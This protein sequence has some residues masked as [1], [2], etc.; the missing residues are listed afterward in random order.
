MDQTSRGRARF[1]VK[2][3]ATNRAV[4]GDRTPVDTGDVNTKWK[5]SPGPKAAMTK[6]ATASKATANEGAVAR[7]AA[8]ANRAAA[9]A[10]AVSKVATDRVKAAGVNKVATAKAVTIAAVSGKANQAITTKVDPGKVAIVVN[11]D[12]PTS[13]RTTPAKVKIGLTTMNSAVAPAGADRTREAL[14]TAAG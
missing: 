5:I 8:T 9:T 6:A 2:M 3:K 4:S 1:R 10:M 12:M 7:K 14:R 11:P 13:I